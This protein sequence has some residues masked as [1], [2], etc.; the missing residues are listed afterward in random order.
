DQ[1][2]HWSK[3]DVIV[4][5]DGGITIR[6]EKKTGNQ[7]DVPAGK[8]T[9]YAAGYLDSF[10][11]WTQRYGYFECRM[12]LPTAPGLWPAFWLMPDRGEGVA[13]RNSTYFGGMEFDILEHLTG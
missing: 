12:K 9:D 3:D 4:H 7:N 10:G 11:K 13:H 2:T 8:Q 6:Y 1:R 5:G